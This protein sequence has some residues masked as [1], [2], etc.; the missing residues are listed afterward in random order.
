MDF[1][2]PSIMNSTVFEGKNGTLGLDTPPRATESS[3]HIAVK[4]NFFREHFGEV[5]GIMIQRVESKEQKADV[6]TKVLLSETL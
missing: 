6:F 3:R 1:A 2:S 5:K 4:H